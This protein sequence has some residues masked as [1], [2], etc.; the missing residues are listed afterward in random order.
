MLSG[1][2][3]FITG[4]EKINEM[5]VHKGNM[6][7]ITKMVA[8]QVQVLKTQCDRERENAKILKVEAEKVNH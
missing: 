1:Q 4:E 8:E 2:F 3:V 7:K 6:E 5:K